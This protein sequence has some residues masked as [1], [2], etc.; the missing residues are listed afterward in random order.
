MKHRGV[1]SIFFLCFGLLLLAGSWISSHLIEM[2]KA[3]QVSQI[4]EYWESD[5]R[6]ALWRLESQLSLFIATEN[7]RPSR[8]YRL[9]RHEM[10][11]N[12]S[13]VKAYFYVNTMDELD[14]RVGKLST[15]SKRSLLQYRSKKE[16]WSR[17]QSL[18]TSPGDAGEGA[19]EKSMI[20][21]DDAELVMGS[22]PKEE[23]F[24][25]NVQLEQQVQSLQRSKKINENRVSSGEKQSSSVAVAVESVPE[26][27]D[28]IA[29]AKVAQR[30]YQKSKPKGLWSEL[31][32]SFSSSRSTPSSYGK[33]ETLGAET[34]V[35]ALQDRAVRG[36]AE[37]EVQNSRIKKLS[38]S[39][40]RSA[41]EAKKRT[42]TAPV[43]PTQSPTE[44]LEAPRV[45]EAV[46]EA[47]V[48]SGDLFLIRKVQK[49]SSTELQGFQMD[50]KALR[51]WAQEQVQDLFTAI[52]LEVSA[53]EPFSARSLV[54]LPLRFAPGEPPQSRGS[55]ESGTLLALWSLWASLAL[56]AIVFFLLIRGML[57][58]SEKKGAF[59]SAVTHEL[60]T[61]LTTFQMYSEMLDEGM[62]SDPNKQK[63]YF[64]TLRLES[65]R[66]AHLVE[67]VLSFSKV[68]NK[69]MERQMVRIGFA[70]LLS[71]S[72][73]RAKEKLEREGGQLILHEQ[74]D[75]E[76]LISCDPAIVE[77]I[78]FNLVENACKY[79]RS[80]G[81]LRVHLKVSAVKSKLWL[82]VIDEGSG[83]SIDFK[84]KLFE[85]FCKSD[86]ES[87][88]T[89][90]GVGL[91]LALCRQL[92]Q[93]CRGDLK[94]L[95]SSAGAHFRLTLPL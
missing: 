34:P 68:E 81:G 41:T 66:L 8:D 87:A 57:R 9:E 22:A 21:K 94:H 60:R 75:M 38:S 42:A 76:T 17:S 62:V 74:V 46:L 5:V 89:A 72:L 82:D 44:A 61:P 33:T 50:L 71:Q 45:V 59:A 48:I 36:R 86:K 35:L 10:P 49:G 53:S 24:F 1:W 19:V 80:D 47:Q 25:E 73:K 31:Q 26:L 69:R 15:E 28:A 30:A 91:G 77:Q 84:K 51:R 56:T 55:L 92:A 20:E 29:R 32:N 13:W 43:L 6:A 93:H 52:T 16:K 23:F 63:R 67:N 7:A 65:D 95:D 83:V 70:E 90:A 2:D 14:V 88:N 18:M 11:W 58:L 78:I 27:D 40:R 12:S 3:R 64:K 54:T 4:S 39:R 85:P 37:G 79:G